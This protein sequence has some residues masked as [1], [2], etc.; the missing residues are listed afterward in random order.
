[1]KKETLEIFKK[2]LKKMPFFEDLKYMIK[3]MG[4]RS[5]AQCGEDIIVSYIFDILDIKD[6]LYLDIGT[7]HPVHLNNTYLLY[8]KGWTGVCIEPDPFLFKKIAAKRKGDKCLNVGVGVGDSANAVDF[9]VMQERTLNTFSADEAKRLN[10]MGYKTKNILKI[11]I[12]NINDLIKKEFDR[13]PNFVS[14]DIEGN[15]F[16]V[17]KSFDFSKN[18]PAVI[19][20]ETLEFVTG[21]HGEKRTDIINYMLENNYFVYADTYI[22]TIFVD[23]V[24]WG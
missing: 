3:S 2:N 17:L 18:R 1:M 6:P 16:Q 20:I 5:Y 11:P 7:N 24:I 13:M 19:C 21:R 14:I 22:N 4:Q 8:K 15:D 12:L 9:F 23:K 10:G